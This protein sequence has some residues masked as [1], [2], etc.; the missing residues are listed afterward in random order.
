MTEQPAVFTLKQ[1]TLPLLIS[2]PHAGTHIPDD[3][4]ATMTPDARFVDDCDWHLERLYGFAAD[5]GASILVP[6]HARYVVDL[7]RPPDNE[8]LYPGQDTTGLVPVDTFDKTPLYPANALPGNDE[9][10]RRRDRY[11]LPYHDAL[12]REIARLKGEH[13]RVLVW[14]AHSIRSHVPR[15]FDGRLPDF[16]FGTS[17]GAS[18]APG[19]AEAL[20]ARVLAHGGYTAVANGRFK[21]GY[22]T[23]HYGVPST[24]V[25]AVQLELSQITYMEET[26]PYAYDE[27]RAAR[28]VPLLQTLVETALAH[29]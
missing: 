3:I 27:A 19:L 8:N 28:I 4:A 26:R 7:N 9:I 17:S 25:E 24:G 18:A 5:L 21:G 2:I 16:N 12:Q 29:R 14:E 6:S 10:M 1:G 15:F 20:A 13:G 11:W 22:I 23:R